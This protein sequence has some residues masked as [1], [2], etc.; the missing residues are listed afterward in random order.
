MDEDAV[1]TDV[2]PEERDSIWAETEDKFWQTFEQT[3]RGQTT[4]AEQEFHN[5]STKIK[6]EMG[7]VMGKQNGLTKAHERMAREMAA[8]EEEQAYNRAALEDQANQLAELERDY[9]EEQQLRI[10]KR[11]QQAFSMKNYFR[12]KRGLEPLE[13]EPQDETNGSWQP[14]PDAME[15]VE[16]TNGH[17]PPVPTTAE[18]LVDVVDADD[19]LIGPVERIEPW[20]QWVE[21][22]QDMPIRRKVKI[23][24]GRRFG[25]DHLATIYERSEAKGVKWLSCMIQAIGEVQTRRCQSCDKNQ[26]AFEKCIIVGGELYPKC[27]NC[28]WNRQGCHGAS[29]EGIDVAAARQ[30]ALEKRE[31]RDTQATADEVAR[32]QEEEEEEARR[33]A[34]AHRQAEM[35]RLQRQQAEQRKLEE[36]HRHMAL[37]AEA[38][39]AEERRQAE[40]RQMELERQDRI[41]QEQALERNHYELARAHSEAQAR[42]AERKLVEERM[43]AHQNRQADERRRADE[44]R[45]AEERRIANSRLPPPPREDYRERD[46]EWDR[47]REWERH[48]EQDRE[49]ERAMSQHA[50]ASTLAQ[51]ALA[52]PVRQTTEPPLAMAPIRAPEPRTVLPSAAPLRA[53]DVRTQL[54][55]GAPPPSGPP[56]GGPI[57][58]APKTKPLSM[59]EMLGNQVP[60]ELRLSS[61]PHEPRERMTPG[62][63]HGSGF[64]PPATGFTPA[65]IRSRPPSHD[66]PTPTVAS[67]EASPQPGEVDISSE[68]LEEITRENLALKDDGTIYTAPLC[69]YGV[70]LEKVGRGHWYWEESWPDVK[71]LIEPQWESWRVKYDN[72]VKLQEEGKRGG[73]SKYQIGRQVNRGNKIFEFLEQGEISPY[74]LLG[75]QYVQSGKGGITSYDTLFRLSETL[76]ELSK[77]KLDITPV[78]WLRHRLWELMESEGNKFNLS[79]TIHDFYHD[80]KLSALRHKHGFKNIGRP[81]GMGVKPRPSTEGLNDN[82]P[83]KRPTQSNDG[84]TETPNSKRRKG[85]QSQNGTP[86]GTPIPE[87]S[88]LVT[89]VFVPPETPASAHLLHRKPMAETGDDWSDADSLTGAQLS[90]WEFR[91]Y[92]VKTR[93]Y[94]SATQATQYWSYQPQNRLM[95]HHFLRETSPPVSFRVHKEPINFS[96]TPEEVEL[97]AWSKEAMRVHLVMRRENPRI[98]VKDGKPRGDIMATFKRERTL[99]RFVEF[100]EQLKIKTINATA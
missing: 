74:Q 85:A 30:Q 41:A 37:M 92:Q 27:G 84:G 80:P 73:S 71:T 94:T 87:P 99:R 21:G 90:K 58:L 78:E 8:N 49:R 97:L 89:H 33:A 17:A 18:T 39:A 6:V 44:Y 50:K 25:H 100:M 43:M 72:A 83:V 63:A 56:P 12:R 1:W 98:S 42:H 14:S 23:R 82:T 32:Q 46:R 15:G 2:P 59:E 79:K 91:M 65:N 61:T 66:T 48:R 57:P 22:I 93:L 31:Q 11:D 86:R 28:E 75:K 24:R 38:Q 70:P 7:T 77:F 4:K 55:T 36:T 16:L 76:A 34:E 68:P 29:R 19:N 95:E 51:K 47:D 60:P 88:P 20:N 52:L 3:N 45:M 35:E 13:P 54:P 81:S 53:P 64:P 26:G 67:V 9:R 69:M 96:F 40:R 10:K 62:F 5:E